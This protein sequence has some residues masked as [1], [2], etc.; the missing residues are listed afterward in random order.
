MLLFGVCLARANIRT[1]R[2]TQPAASGSRVVAEQ[3]IPVAATAWKLEAGVIFLLSSS[4][5]GSLLLIM[6]SSACRCSQAV[7]DQVKT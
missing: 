2:Y 6:L 5:A 3:C 7:T 1:L 4:W